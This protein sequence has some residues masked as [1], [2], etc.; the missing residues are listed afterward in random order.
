MKA[1]IFL[2]AAIA[3]FAG[4]TLALSGRV[5]SPEGTPVAGA[6]I[7]VA[8]AVAISDSQGQFL[9]TSAAGQQTLRVL[10]A[11]YS[12]LVM[13]AD[14]SGETDLRI[15]LQRSSQTSVTVD[16]TPG[17]APLSSREYDAQTLT[18]RGPGQPG[19]PVSIP[20][21][22]AETPSGGIKAPQYFAPG[23]AGDHGEPIAQYI[24]VGDYQ[25]QNNLPANAH[26]NGYA[27]PNLLIPAAIGF[28]TAD[29]GASD[30]RHGNNAVNVSVAFAPRPRLDPFLEW[31]ADRRNYDVTAGWSPA[32][33][34]T[35]AFVA[36]EMTGGDGYLGFAEHRRQ[37]KL[38]AL[39]MFTSGRHQWTIFGA[40]YRG[41][42]RLPGLTPIVVRLKDDTID[43]RQ[44]DRTST[45]LL[46]ASDTWRL[47][48]QSQFQFSIFSRTYSL[49]LASNFGEGLIQQSERRIVA[50]GNLGF[51]RRLSRWA[52]L[53]SGLDG[54]RDAPRDVRL[55]REDT[56]G[57]LQPVTRND[58]TIGTLASYASLTGEPWRFLG[59]RLGVR[60]DAVLFSNTDGL[61][62][63][64][65]YRHS[66]GI[67]SPKGTLVLRPP[68]RLPLPT[69]SFSYGTAFHTN[70]PRLASAGF[71]GTLIAR[72]RVYQLE[73]VRNIRGYELRMELARV[74]NSSQLAK[75][76]AD[77]GLAENV[78][79]SLV[80]S[81]TVRAKRRFS[82]GALE[83]SFARATAVQ[84]DTRENVPEA[85]RLIWSIAGLTNRL[86]LRL[87]ARAGFD[88]V[89]RR[90]LGEGFT[91]IP[92]RTLRSSFQRP[93]ASGRVDAGLRLQWGGGYTGQTVEA[94][95]LA[96]EALTRD[97]V[98][99]VRQTSYAALTFN[100]HFRREG[101]AP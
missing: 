21:L 88:Y 95:R 1:I 76:D 23:V 78:G 98:V 81:L 5:V 73:A 46:A 18:E 15:E 45:I 50:G 87:Q 9:V 12:G 39:R 4:D 66:T 24:Q 69:V 92:I 38:N 74:S 60:R 11:G 40:A 71:P 35:G 84:R 27:D 51:G 31:S 20:G 2:T 97:R 41:F 63:F 8:G 30:V 101:T 52:S 53:E 99:G 34:S 42:S 57:I 62:P 55:S 13:H 89:G 79:P 3:L 70:D 80:R 44:F 33:P 59:Y 47:S 72:S 26:G 83:S 36:V 86:P 19:V 48:D 22:P 54:R 17:F 6:R 7:E 58:Y 37:Y 43:P 100:Y 75:L 25:V 49:Q 56:E 65:S 82:F 91:A 29:V 68:K 16:A 93:F 28:A 90:P 85:P 67:S 96:G 77:T 64:H 32:N 61:E 10:A 14:L 94:L